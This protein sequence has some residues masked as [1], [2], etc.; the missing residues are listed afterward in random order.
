MPERNR[1]AV[2]SRVA[3]LKRARERDAS[4]AMKELEA[5]RVATLAKTARLRAERLARAAEERPSPL[6]KIAKRKK[7]T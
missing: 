6:K 1:Q 3:E 5:A 2:L 7:K 4:Q